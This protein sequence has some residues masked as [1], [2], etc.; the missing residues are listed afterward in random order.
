[1]CACI[2]AWY[3]SVFSSPALNSQ[4]PGGSDGANKSNQQRAILQTNTVPSSCQSQN[5]MHVHLV[6]LLTLVL[7]ILFK[8]KYIFLNHLN[9]MFITVLRSTLS[10]SFCFPSLFRKGTLLFDFHSVFFCCFF[11]GLFYSISLPDLPVVTS[12]P[13]LLLLLKKAEITSCLHKK[14]IIPI[15]LFPSRLKK[16]YF[17]SF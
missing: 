3:Q 10:R 4:T 14:E 9:K 6:S 11:L 15:V 1:M 17:A 2:S 13:P 8:C 12:R 16:L 5:E 7:L